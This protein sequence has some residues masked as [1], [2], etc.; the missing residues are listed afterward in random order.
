M[1]RALDRWLIPYLRQKPAPEIEPGS[2]HLIVAVCDHYEPLHAADHQTAVTRVRR[3]LH[4]Y[5]SAVAPFRDSRGRSP[6]HTFFYPIEKYHPDIVGPVAELCHKTGSELEIHLHHAGDTEVTLAE[7][8]QRGLGEFS[9]HTTMSRR[10]DGTTG[11]AFVHGNWALQNCDPHNRNCGVRNEITTLRGAGCYADFTFPSAPHPTQPRSVNSIGYIRD[12]G[13]P[14]DLDDL[15]LATVQRSG[16]LRDASDH[17]LTVQGPL[18]LNWSH[19]KWGL[20]PKIE[21]ADLTGNN[22]PTLERLQLWSRTHITVQHRPEWRFIKLHTHGATPRTSDMFL[23]PVMANFHRALTSQKS[24][25]VHYTNAREMTNIIHA[26]E[27]GKS[28]DPDDY[29]DYHLTR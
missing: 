17:L 25:A 3:W 9:Q 29:L 26:A 16:L 14:S 5:P 8:L 23:G 19:R 4:D 18:A 11:F 12:T 24:Y 22:P 28:G 27:D 13:T 1:L 21:N 7:K 2:A 10:P 20:I 15:Q 6:R